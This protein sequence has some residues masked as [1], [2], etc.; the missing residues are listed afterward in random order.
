MTQFAVYRNPRRSAEH[1]PYL[2][3]LQSDLAPR[4]MCV[5]VPLVDPGYFGLTAKTLNP[6]VKVLGE[7]YVVSPMEIG[8]LPRG[9]LG[10]AVADLRASRQEVLAAMDFLLTGF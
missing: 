2:L 7:S 8:S 1:A 5:V 9:Q 3:E 6:L 4:P 10:A